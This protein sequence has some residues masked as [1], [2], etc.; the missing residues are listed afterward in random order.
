MFGIRRR[1]PTPPAAESPAEAV[2]PSSPD[3]TPAPP[4]AA[5]PQVQLPATRRIFVARQPVFDREGEAVAYELLFREGPENRFT[6]TDKDL[7][8]AINIEQ[9]TAA[10]GLDDLVGQRMAFVNLSRRALVREYYKL[11]PRERTVVELLEDIQPD[12]EVLEACRELKEQGYR[13]ALDD[14]TDSPN[15]L[16][17]L[18]Y[19][20]LV[21]VDF[22]RAPNA[23][24]PLLVERMR[25]H[26]VRM[27]A[28]KVETQ[29]EHGSAMVAGYDLFQG[30][31]YCHP[32]MIEAHDLPPTKLSHLRFLAAV[33]REEASF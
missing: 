7:A 20:D 14:F 28:E 23:C 29:D 25:R 22:R 4:V 18:A 16:P 2:I 30:Y 10:F 11:L 12:R 33:S 3:P 13:L 17:L 32:Q 21:K 24:D 15:A 8:S 9:S 27:L 26:G 31:Y 1:R 5:A 19:A 6:G